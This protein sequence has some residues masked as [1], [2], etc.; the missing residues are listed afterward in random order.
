MHQLP[1]TEVIF[2]NWLSSLTYIASVSKNLFACGSENLLLVSVK[3]IKQT[4]CRTWKDSF[5]GGLGKQVSEIIDSI[6][7]TECYSNYR[8]LK[9]SFRITERYCVFTSFQVEFLSSNRVF[10]YEWPTYLSQLFVKI[11]QKTTNFFEDLS[12]NCNIV[13]R[14][15]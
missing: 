12:P 4:A 11:Y 9:S 13:F 6:S 7:E 5:Y 15:T 14:L 2:V 8:K 10:F 1:M 3:I